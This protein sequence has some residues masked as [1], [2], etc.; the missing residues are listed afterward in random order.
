MEFVD[1]GWRFV[2]IAIEGQQTDV[3]GINPWE[4]EWMPT[5]QRITVAHPEYPMQRHTMDVYH[6]AGAIPPITFAAGEFSSGVWGFFVP[7]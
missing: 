3:G 7:I 1:D 6:V 2:G 5:D 4:V